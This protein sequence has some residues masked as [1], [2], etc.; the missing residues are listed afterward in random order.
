MIQNVTI[1]S[2]CPPNPMMPCNITV[3]A[4]ATPPVGNA[5]LK[6][7]FPTATLYGGTTQGPQQMSPDSGVTNGYQATFTG[8]PG[9]YSAS[10]TAIWIIPTESAPDTNSC[11]STPVP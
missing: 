8:P 10:V 6:P 1:T 9:N 11:P 5:Y 2:V 7:G 4:Q 3:K